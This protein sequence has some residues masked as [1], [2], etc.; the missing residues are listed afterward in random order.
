MYVN[1]CVFTTRVYVCKFLTRSS[2]SLRICM[3]KLSCRR[4][5]DTSA[6]HMGTL[7]GLETSQSPCIK[8]THRESKRRRQSV[9]PSP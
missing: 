2:L 8:L 5:F 4:R 9:S 1:M 6:S 3:G 7:V